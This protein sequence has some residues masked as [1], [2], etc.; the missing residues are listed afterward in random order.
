[1]RPASVEVMDQRRPR[2]QLIYRFL[3]AVMNI[4]RKL[5]EKRRRRVCHVGNVD[6][7]GVKNGNAVHI[8]LAEQKRKPPPPGLRAR[9]VGLCDG[10]NQNLVAVGER[11]AD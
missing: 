2:E 3:M 9:I 10:G 4:V 1:M 7:L 6:R 8:I 11:N 5:T